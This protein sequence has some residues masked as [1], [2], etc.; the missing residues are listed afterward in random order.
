ME[1]TGGKKPGKIMFS[2]DIDTHQQLEDEVKG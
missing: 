1:S 2:G